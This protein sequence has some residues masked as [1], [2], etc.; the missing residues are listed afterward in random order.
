MNP[1]PNLERLV[2]W[3]PADDRAVEIHSQGYFHSAPRLRDVVIKGHQLDPPPLTMDLPWSQLTHLETAVLGWHGC[4]SLLDHLPQ[5]RRGKFEIA[6]SL[7]SEDLVKIMHKE[8]SLLHLEHLDLETSVPL[9]KLF[10]LIRAPALQVLRVQFIIS[11]LYESDAG[12]DLEFLASIALFS[13]QL[14]SLSLLALF[15][16]EK[17]MVDFLQG[18]PSLIE[19]TLEDRL[20]SQFIGDQLLLELTYMGGTCLCPKLETI[21]LS[22]AFGLRDDLVIRLEESR[23]RPEP[24]R[25]SLGCSQA[26]YDLPQTANPPILST[27]AFTRPTNQLI[28]S[29]SHETRLESTRS[30]PPSE[31]LSHP[32][33]LR[34]LRVGASRYRLRRLNTSMSILNNALERRRQARAQ[35]ES[36]SHPGFHGPPR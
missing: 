19:L 16:S 3:Y 28:G 4:V 34:Y 10:S 36:Q 18:L 11:A 13:S 22:S 31:S 14:H 25:Q 27:D 24:S 12:S 7:A 15:V 33:R 6:W 35:A 26:V 1:F 5:L 32:S 21:S 2:I 20:D 9:S 17:E 30:M 23:W 29:C 8:I